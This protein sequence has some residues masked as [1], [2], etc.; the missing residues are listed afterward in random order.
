MRGRVLSVRALMSQGSTPIG[1]LLV[2]WICEAAGPRTGIAVGGVFAILS[3]SLT[4]LSR[5][6]ALRTAYD[7]AD[8]LRP[9]VEPVVGETP[10]V[11]VRRGAAATVPEELTEGDPNA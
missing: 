11:A 9:G 1:S 3:S 10:V 2:G 5:R 8:E 7:H 6:R 4:L